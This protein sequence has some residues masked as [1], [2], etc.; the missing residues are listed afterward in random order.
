MGKSTVAVNLA[1][2]F[3][4]KKIGLFDADL[5]GP[6]I[7]DLLKNMDM[8]RKPY[9]DGM[10][11]YPAIFNNIK[12]ASTGFITN[13]NDNCYV[14]GRV[15][16]GTLSQLLYDVDWD[17]DILIIDLPPGTNDI[18]RSLF[19]H[20][21][22]SAILVTTPQEISFSDTQRGLDFL[23]RLEIKTIGVIENMGSYQCTSCGN[24]EKIFSADTHNEFLIPNDLEMLACFPL[25]IDLNSS[26]KIPYVIENPNNEI[27]KNFSR[28]A[29]YIIEINKMNSIN[30]V[31]E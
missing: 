17:I 12:V 28:I 15:L 11:I 19:Y 16:E 26:K 3:K 23:N 30:K 31:M 20:L 25:T 14:T 2:S 13:K 27:S 24:K 4:N 29:N 21:K 18:H 5:E 6:S 7:P 9:M 8:T 10:V 1:Y 22:G